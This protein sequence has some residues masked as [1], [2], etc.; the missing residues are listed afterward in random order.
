MAACGQTILTFDPEFNF[1]SST[2]SFDQQLHTHGHKIRFDELVKGMPVPVFTCDKEG[3]LTFYNSAAVQLWSYEPLPGVETWH[4]AWQLFDRSGRLLQ[5]EE[6]PVMKALREKDPQPFVIIVRGYDQQVRYLQ[7]FPSLIFSEENEPE[8]AC[9]TLIDITGQK[10]GEE[11]Q[12]ILS[13]IV[14]SSDDAIIS[15]NLDGMI[16]SWNAGA[17]K[18]FGYTEPEVLGKHISI[19]IPKALQAEEERI[20]SNIRAGKKIDHF[21]TIRL[22]KSGREIPISLTV[23]PIKD[24]SGTITGAS[25]IARDVSERIHATRVIEETARRLELLYA[26]GNTIS[27]K[28]DA[29]TILQRVTDATTQITGA[30]FGAFFYNTIN[31]QGESF[32]LYTLSGAC[33]EEFDSFGMPRNTAV[34][35]PTFSGQGIVRSDDI[36]KDPR[37]GHNAPHYGQPAGH[38]PVVSYLAVPV[39][40]VSGEV[41]GGLFF[42]HPDPG[43]FKE[44][45]EDIVSSIASQAAAALDNSRLFEEVKSVSAKKDEFIALASHELKTPLTSIKGYLQILG[46]SVSDNVGKIFIDKMINQVEK[47]N[48]LV[49]DLFDVSK[50]EAGKLQFNFELFDLNKLLEDNLETFHYTVQSHR[51]VPGQEAGAVWVNADKQ[52]IEQ[53]IVNLVTNA[54]KYS[55]HADTVYVRLYHTEKHACLEVRDEGIGLSAAQQQ[56][57]FTRFYRAEGTHDI[58]GLGLG[59]YLSKEIMDRHR[60]SL[61]VTSEPGKGSAFLCTLPLATAPA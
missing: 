35:H 34:F 22:H 21:Q 13:A 45:H 1:M 9:Y 14:T 3:R 40:S 28:L 18:I 2:R 43:V 42:G 41:I 56:Q 7:V 20:I 24:A 54:I 57:I 5:P 30:A 61:T 12:A 47:L 31:E 59:L 19:L 6:S 15:K 10:T 25:K 29:N 26:I 52:R 60:G 50:I 27:E 8:G 23:S 51:I 4:H 55:P 11:K 53:V 44:E 48:S 16:L 46:R 32:M 38:L 33:K 39:V 36:R 37:Y 49:T 58:P 17:Q